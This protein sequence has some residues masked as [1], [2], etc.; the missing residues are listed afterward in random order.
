MTRFDT[1]RV[2]AAQATPVI[3]DAEASVDKAVRLIG[4][5]AADGAQLV[6]LPETF[7]SLYPSQIWARVAAGFSGFDE[8]WDRLWDS[9]VDVPGPLVDRLVEECRKH[10]VHCVIGV[11]ERESD[12][13]GSLYNAMLLLGPDGLLW[14]HRKLMPT[15]H[16]RLFHGVGK[17]DDLQV[18]DTPFGRVG[19]LICWENRMPLARYAMYQGGP[20]I[21][22]APTADDSD[23]WLAS[24]RHI[25]MESGAF[26]VSVP[27]FIPRS[28]FPED[29]PVELPDREVFGKGG[30][31]VIDPQW[32]EVIAGPLYGE[33]GMLIADCDLRRALHAKRWFDAVGHYSREDVLAA[34]P[35][36]LPERPD[37]GNGADAS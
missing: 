12:R 28:A 31:A 14:K 34:V 2:A 22:V 36:A 9:S 27:Q 24:M 17:G 3:L 30:A 16:E 23:G 13:P 18:A 11:N 19:G 32:G 7:V 5:A 15:H 8:L 6:V 25:A 1:V 26:V 4:E 29:F 37:A 21:W 20:Q 33:E 35:P 10:G